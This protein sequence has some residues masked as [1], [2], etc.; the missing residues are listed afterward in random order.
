MYVASM[1]GAGF[2]VR[3]GRGAILAATARVIARRGYRGA[4]V[5]EIAMEAG[6]LSSFVRRT[7]GDEEDCFYALF[8]ATF[9]QTFTRVLDRTRDVPWPESARDGLALF[10]ELL[11]AQPVHVRACVDGVRALGL[12]G[13]LRLDTAVEAFTAFLAP[14]FE[15]LRGRGVPVFQ[16]N[17]IG[18]T[19]VHVIT[20]HVHDDRIE[21]LPRALPQLLSIALIPFCDT[22]DI[23]AL[24]VTT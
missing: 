6:V 23:D 1:S 14:G 8:S 22:R 18:S 21:E 9:H 11:A 7:V 24:L 20:Q 4:T 10:L 12:D 13:S 15:A 3:T 19:V 16:G 17:L 2:Q 5:S